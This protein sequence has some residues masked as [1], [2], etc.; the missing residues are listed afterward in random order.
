[1]IIDN[2]KP[3]GGRAHAKKENSENPSSKDVAK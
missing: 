2:G 1:L 3:D